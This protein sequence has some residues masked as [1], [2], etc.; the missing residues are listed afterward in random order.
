MK[1]IKLGVIGSS[2]G[3]G[4]P[5]SWSAICNGYD[6]YCMASCPYPEI[7]E[8]LS[9]QSFPDDS[10]N[11]VTVSHIWTQDYSNSL[12]ISKS[13]NIPNIVKSFS[14]LIGQVDGILLARDDA[15]NHYEFAKPF[16]EAGIPIYI[17]KPIAYNVD[18]AN[19]LFALQKYEGQIFTCSAL[20]YAKEFDD[21]ILAGMGNIYCVNAKVVKSWSKYA[22]HLLDPILKFISTEVVKH[23]VVNNN[24]VV[25]CNYITANNQAVN[26]ITS[27]SN[28]FPIEVEFFC[29]NG[30]KK[31]EFKDVFFAFKQ[32]LQLFVNS[33][34]FNNMYISKKDAIDRIR[35]LELGMESEVV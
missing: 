26:I 2:V 34:R 35:W 4:H 20:R 14:E 15:E 23:S 31:V 5:Y 28:D 1:E 24:C 6:D 25:S 30:Y 27:N 10:I 32:A 29:E 9:C 33:I 3:N 21:N 13:S 7:Y 18:D 12:A 17:D 19:K 8:Y 16:I 22:I 11:G